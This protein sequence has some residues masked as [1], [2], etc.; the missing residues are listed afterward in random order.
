MQTFELSS[1]LTEQVQSG[2]A[3]VEFLRVP[4]LSMGVYMLPADGVDGQRPHNEDEVYYVVRGRAIINVSG[5]DRAVEPG[6]L[7]YVAAHAPHHFH[8]ISE[9][10]AVL[11]FF[12]PAESE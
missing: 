2:E 7:I 6:S 11:V 3:Y 9:E 10:L 4:A 1:L 5:E 12:A 8:S